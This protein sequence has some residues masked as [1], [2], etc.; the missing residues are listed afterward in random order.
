MTVF[1]EAN[2]FESMDL[3]ERVELDEFGLRN[4]MGRPEGPMHLHDFDWRELDE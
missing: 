4:V 1:E 3:E 2:G